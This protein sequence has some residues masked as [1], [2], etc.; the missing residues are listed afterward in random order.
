M[1]RHQRSRLRLDVGHGTS[2]GPHHLFIQLEHLTIAVGVLLGELGYGSAG[3]LQVLVDAQAPTVRKGHGPLEFRPDM[4]DVVLL[5]QLEVP[6]DGSIVHHHVEYGM[7]VMEVIR[8]RYLLG[9]QTSACLMPLLQ[10]QD[11][12]SRLT[13]IG[14]NLQ[15]VGTRPDYYDIILILH[16]RLLRLALI[17][18]VNPS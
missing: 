8:Q 2:D 7:G 13:Q 14:A 17:S 4:P 5:F 10:Q 12:L 9:G 16:F 6:E 11:L 1:S 3:L 18:E 15:A